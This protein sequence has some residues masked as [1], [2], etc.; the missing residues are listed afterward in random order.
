[1]D[2]SPVRFEVFAE[3]SE[4]INTCWKSKEDDLEP[5]KT[6]ISPSFYG[7]GG[8]YS[9]EGLFGLSVLN[10]IIGHCK[11]EC[12]HENQHFK[13]LEG[14]ISLLVDKDSA[15]SHLFITSLDIQI[16]IEGC[17]D[18]EAVENILNHVI[19]KSPITNSIKS[20]KT[21]HFDIS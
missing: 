1:M 12:E 2:S 3:T 15:T 8:G 5:I 21:F 9:P 19:K 4:G 7:P 13:K 6:A 11:I 16:T 18:K 20:A 10:C 17:S 14:K